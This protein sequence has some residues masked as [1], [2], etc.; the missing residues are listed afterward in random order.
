MTWKTALFAVGYFWVFLLCTLSVLWWKKRK[1][2]RR[3]PFGKELKLLRSPG[4]TQ[5]KQVLKFEEDLLL[6][7]T[8]AVGIPGTVAWILFSE[9]A[10]SA[11]PPNSSASSSP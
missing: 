9:S 4:E 3:N 2:K 5:L 11:A 10:V 7:V 8:L 1:K 6:R